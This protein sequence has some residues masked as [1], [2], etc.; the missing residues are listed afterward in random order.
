V[1]EEKEKESEKEVRELEA[2]TTNSIKEKLD[3]IVMFPL[4]IST[5]IIHCLSGFLFELIIYF[6]GVGTNH[7][8]T[9]ELG[10]SVS[11]N[12]MPRVQ[13]FVFI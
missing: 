6:R 9:F 12:K 4:K 13:L 8:T 11:I 5:Q 7:L 2:N 1:L 3:R 10:I